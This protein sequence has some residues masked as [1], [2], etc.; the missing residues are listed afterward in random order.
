MTSQSFTME[1][2]GII[3]DEMI[4]IMPKCTVHLQGQQNKMV[5]FMKPYILTDLNNGV[6]FRNYTC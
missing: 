5:P 4:H 6:K 2:M 3:L 1:E